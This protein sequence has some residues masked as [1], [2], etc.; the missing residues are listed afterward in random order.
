[1]RASRRI[2]VYDAVRAASAD[3]YDAGE[4]RVVRDVAG[5][6]GLDEAAVAQIDALV[7][8]E[9]ALKLKRIDVLMP[10][11]HPNLAPR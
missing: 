11:G 2:L 8:E 10:D 4:K 3:G 1:L 9:R 7:A 5:A 6:L